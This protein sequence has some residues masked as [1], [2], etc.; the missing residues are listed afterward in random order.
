MMYC[1]WSIAGTYSL[2]QQHAAH[3]MHP[4]RM[5]HCISVQELHIASRPSVLLE[6]EFQNIEA[7]LRALETAL[8]GANVR[9]LCEQQPLFLNTDVGVVLEEIRRCASL[10]PVIFNQHSWQLGVL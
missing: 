10:S 9:S 8:P 1:R 5:Q 7:K 3:C 4:I 2:C 6:E